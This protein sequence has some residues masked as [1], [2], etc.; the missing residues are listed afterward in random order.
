[1]RKKSTGVRI[2]L[3]PEVEVPHRT[4]PKSVKLPGRLL[5][6]AVNGKNIL[7]LEVPKGKVKFTSTSS[8]FLS[9]SC[10]AK[11][12]LLLGSFFEVQDLEGNLIKRNSSLCA[13]CFRNSG[14]REGVS[15]KFRCYLCG[16]QW[17]V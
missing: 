11:F 12:E 14:A 8:I 5:T 1:M 13:K 17:E 2:L 16:Y 15:N 4:N 3:S 7:V 10:Y 6:E 9:V